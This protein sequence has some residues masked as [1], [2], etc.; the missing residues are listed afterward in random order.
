[1]IYIFLSLIVLKINTKFSIS[2]FILL[3]SMLILFRFDFA[4]ANFA[5]QELYAKELRIRC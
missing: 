5:F 2:Y 3:H 1:M 4:L